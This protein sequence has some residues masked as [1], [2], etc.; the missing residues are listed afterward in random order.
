MNPHWSW[1]WSAQPEILA[2]FERCADKYGL[3]PHLRLRTEIQSARWDEDAQQWC[4]TTSAGRQHRFDVVVSAVGLFTRPQF[5]E[6]VEQEPFTGTVM[7]SSQWDHSLDLPGA[8]VAVLGTG[9]TAS[10]LLPEL[11]KVAGQV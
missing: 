4:L 6:L 9:S 11:A 2:Y 5:P 3:R 7:H 8:R 10:Q 1:L